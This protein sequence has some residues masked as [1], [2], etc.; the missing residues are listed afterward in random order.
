MS[1]IGC[2]R[3]VA[4]ANAGVGFGDLSFRVDS[5]VKVEAGLLLTDG[6]VVNDAVKC[7]GQVLRNRHVFFQF[8]STGAM[9]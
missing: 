5:L 8:S 4:V 9:E 1:L 6:K 3:V 7:I 2:R